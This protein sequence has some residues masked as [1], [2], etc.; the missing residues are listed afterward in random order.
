MFDKV[1]TI[2]LI[3]TLIDKEDNELWYTQQDKSTIQQLI[4][5][6]VLNKDEEGEKVDRTYDLL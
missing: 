6:I 5:N 3:M 1:H 4:S 2:Q